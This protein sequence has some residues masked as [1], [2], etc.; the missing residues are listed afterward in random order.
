MGGWRGGSHQPA[1]FIQS[2]SP[3]PVSFTSIASSLPVFS[4]VSSC[5]LLWS[6]FRASPVQLIPGRNPECYT[7]VHWGCGFPRNSCSWGT[8]RCIHPPPWERKLSEHNHYESMPW[9]H[10]WLG[11]VSDQTSGEGSLLPPSHSKQADSSRMPQ[12]GGGGPS[13]L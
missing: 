7:A 13:I 3:Y 9:H 5:V 6:E 2:K 11:G 12:T 8:I 10:W 4:H 1:I